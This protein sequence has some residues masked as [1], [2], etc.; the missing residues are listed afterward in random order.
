MGT[1]VF[2]FPK[3]DSISSLIILVSGVAFVAAWIGYGRTLGY[4]GLQ[5]GFCFYTVVFRGP[6]PETQVQSARDALVGIAVATAVMWLVFDQIWPVRTVVAMRLTFAE[7]GDIGRPI[8]SK[9]GKNRRIEQKPSRRYE[10]DALSH[11]A[12]FNRHP[13]AERNGF[14]LISVRREK[15]F[16]A[17]LMRFRVW[18]WKFQ[19]SFGTSSHSPMVRPPAITHLSRLAFLQ[20]HVYLSFSI[21]RAFFDSLF[22]EVHWA[23][24]D[25]TELQ[26]D[27]RNAERTLEALTNFRAC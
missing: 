10:G 17:R 16:C 20:I 13:D 26:R 22:G 12:R 8:R 18:P 15:T 5:L 2:L 3:M 27:K 19:A 21:C 24:A 7:F 25:P 11:R 6:A 14:T 9:H 1:I 23:L 4:L